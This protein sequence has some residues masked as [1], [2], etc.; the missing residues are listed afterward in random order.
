M[1]N[2]TIMV[3]DDSATIRKIIQRELAKTDYEVILATNWN[4]SMINLN[5]RQT[6]T[7][8]PVHITEDILPE[9][10]PQVLP[11]AKPYR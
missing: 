5:F 7:A 2:T 4:Y 1:P 11:T 3:V 8:S 10:S 9:T 6:M